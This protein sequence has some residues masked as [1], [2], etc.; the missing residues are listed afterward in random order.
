MLLLEKFPNI[1]L[2]EEYYQRQVTAIDRVLKK[3]TRGGVLRIATRDMEE[4]GPGFRF[5][6]DSSTET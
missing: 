2:E 3:E 5:S 1:A 4:L 6:I